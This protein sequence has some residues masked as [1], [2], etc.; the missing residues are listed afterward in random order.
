MDPMPEKVDLTEMGPSSL[1][2]ALL[3][4]DG[5]ANGASSTKAMRGWEDR[6]FAIREEILRR[7]K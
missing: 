1:I 5:W 3:F 6:R 7:M 2:D 4:A